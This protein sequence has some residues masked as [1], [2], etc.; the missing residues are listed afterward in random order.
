VFCGTYGFQNITISTA[1]Y[2]LR[3]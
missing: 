3:W 2:C 1:W